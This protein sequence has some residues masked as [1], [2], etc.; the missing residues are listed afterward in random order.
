MHRHSLKA[1]FFWFK[2]YSLLTVNFDVTG[3]LRLS[4]NSMIKWKGKEQ[5]RNHSYI[6]E[7]KKKNTECVEFCEVRDQGKTLKNIFSG[8]GKIQ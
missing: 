7:R 1:V 4:V 5:S 3:G 8:T 6:Y 2:D